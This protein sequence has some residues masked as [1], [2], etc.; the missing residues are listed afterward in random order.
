MSEQ[1]W[2]GEVMTGDASVVLRLEEQPGGR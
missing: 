2:A 1:E